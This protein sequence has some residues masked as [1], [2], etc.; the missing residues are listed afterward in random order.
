MNKFKYVIFPDRLYTFRI[1][2]ED[3]EVSGEDL[4]LAFVDIK[5]KRDKMSKLDLVGVSY[6]I[7]IDNLF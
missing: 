5:N 1:D 7:D 6:E 3:V 2:G 4:Y